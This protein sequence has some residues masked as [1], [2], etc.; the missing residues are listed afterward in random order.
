MVDWSGGSD[1][2]QKPRKDAIWACVARNGTHETPVYLRNR[3]LAERWLADLIAEELDAGRRLMLGFDFPFGY[4]VGFA[5]AVTGT[6]DPLILWDWFAD[7]I[8]DAPDRN[9][10]FDLAG[11]INRGFGGQGPFWGNG[12]KR[13]VTGL[14]RNKQ[15]Y[16]NP[17]P[18]RRAVEHLAKGSFT[19]WQMSGAGAVGGQVMMGL[20]V[21][22]RLRHRFAA[23]IAV[24]PFEA[25][26]KPVAFVEI[27]PSLTLGASPTDR[28]KDA[29]QV[30]RVVRHIAGL[31]LNALA[32]R[33]TV[34]AP[35]EGWILG[36]D[37]NRSTIMPP[38]LRNDC[39][40]LP[41]GV[42][43]TPVDEALALLHDR[44]SPVA[45]IEEI[46]VIEGL[47]RV[48]A[49]GCV[50]LRAN[51]P[52]PN[53]AV[54][55][56]GFSGGLPEGVHVLP[57]V[58]GRS[59]A[60]ASFGG[61]VPAGHAIRVL[62]GATLPEGVDTIALQEDV[63]VEPGRIALNGPLKTGANARQ[64]GE[65]VAQGDIVL[66]A[67]RVLSAADL[68]LATAV[69]I[70]HLRVRKPLKV[71]VLSTG[72]ELTD[73][74]EDAGRDGIYDANRPMLLAALR[75]FG[76]EPVDMGR[77]GDDRAALKQRLDATAKA[78]DAILTS[79]GAS[80]GDEDH[81]SAL[82]REAGAMQEWRIAIKPG[83]PLALGLWGGKPVFGLPG[84]PVAALVCTLIFARPALA[85]LSGAGWSEP[86]GYDLPAA[87]EKRKKPGRREYLRARVREGRV[88]V[89]ASE[90]SG[91][92]SGLSW[93]EGLVVLDDGACHIIPG[94]AVRYI[95][96][97]S[98]GL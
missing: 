10:R 8:E 51:P 78:A 88:E 62:T 48:L 34:D 46:P 97:A 30:E 25:L 82:L 85:Q 29:W 64:A 93:A 55:G 16:E 68:A 41:A 92:I 69:G 74:G 12:L 60:G 59:A 98:F 22:A 17:F 47:G 86:Q 77:V 80:D 84:N 32:Q 57:L 24:W 39:F 87:F 76:H 21:L 33:L 28:I 58:E 50:A 36:V 61:T 63:T 79:G 73:P 89:F 96:Y 3:G 6:D 27:W 81:M 44:L 91:R 35:E 72:D 4:P 1:T 18:D 19:C 43:W 56:Y 5:R 66:A 42:T 90:G 14:P 20:P 15:G 37:Q 40:S 7:R 49:E 75:A 31:P 38:P 45:P 94:D 71:A 54:D 53:T 70:A 65:D 2:G 83:R 95:P 67:G 23:Q 11:Q 52:Q 26:D 9:N 13:D